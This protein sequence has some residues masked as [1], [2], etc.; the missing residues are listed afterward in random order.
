MY[1][2]S[3]Y[4]HPIKSLL[5][6]AINE[7]SVNTLGFPHDRTFALLRQST[8]Q[9]L[10]I[11]QVSQ[12]CLFSVELDGSEALIVRFN[13]TGDT[14]RLPLVPKLGREIEVRMHNSPCTSFHVSDAADSFFSQHLGFEATL[15][16]LG[17][18]SR[19]VL[20]NVAPPPSGIWSLL[21]YKP[22]GKITFADCAPLLVTT[23]ASLEEVSKRCG[24]GVDVRKFRPNVVVSPDSDDEEE[25]AAFE[26][27]YW[28][29]LE[30]GEGVN[31]ELTANCA[32]CSS[33]NVD[34]STGGLVE[35]EKQ[36]LKMMQKDRRV[37]PGM[38]Y[39]PVFGRYG[40][41]G[42]AR[43]DKELFLKVGD[44]VKITQ[45]NKERTEFCKFPVPCVEICVDFWNRLA[46]TIDWYSGELGV[47]WLLE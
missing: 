38:K 31:I 30:M 42:A 26:E 8:G 39:S 41:L 12:L 1:I 15:V 36:P 25:M 10:H 3:L 7:T 22:E 6:I 5:P 29:G 28:A 35:K 19:D 34:F 44:K 11:G 37:D 23:S 4:I 21:G 40:F 24:E 13:P 17:N 20:G 33:V 18:S 43:G 47:G 45:K 32:R 14:L 16:F 27:D 9:T 46:G 2:S